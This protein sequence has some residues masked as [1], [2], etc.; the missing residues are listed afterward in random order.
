[1]SFVTHSFI[2]AYARGTASQK[3]VY[4][5]RYLLAIARHASFT[6]SAPHPSGAETTKLL[7]ATPFLVI[8]VAL[9]IPHPMSCSAAVVA[10]R[11]PFLVVKA[12]SVSIS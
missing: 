11:R 9:I 2:D 8:T 6:A 10:A 7:F 3:V 1:L 4:G 5:L 12:E